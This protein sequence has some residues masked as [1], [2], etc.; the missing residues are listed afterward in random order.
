MMAWRDKV[1]PPSTASR[2]DSYALTEKVGG[3]DKRPSKAAYPSSVVYESSAN[4]NGKRL[5]FDLACSSADLANRQM[6]NAKRKC[7]HR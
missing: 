3:G 1:A 7:L 5:D 2:Y 4:E 6:L